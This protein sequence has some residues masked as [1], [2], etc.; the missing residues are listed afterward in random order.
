MKTDNAIIT[1]DN[2]I[3]TPDKMEEA[4]LKVVKYVFD[5]LRS[6]TSDDIDNFALM[7]IRNDGA[8]MLDYMLKKYNLAIPIGFIDPTSHRDDVYKENRQDLREKESSKLPEGGI[9][10]K[11]II[12][13]DSVHE[14]GR[15]ARAAIDTLMDYGRPASVELVVLLERGG[16]EVPVRPTCSAIKNG[17]VPLEFEVKL[18][19]EN[20]DH[21]MALNPR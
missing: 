6:K 14:T 5:S 20:E 3:I 16:H 15:T 12:M 17:H 13:V 19:A 11:H 10:N 4:Y 1:P 9:D 7:A 2:V 18:C 21:Y 8:L